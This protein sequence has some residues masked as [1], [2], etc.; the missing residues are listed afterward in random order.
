[1]NLITVGNCGGESGSGIGLLTFCK[2]SFEI[3]MAFHPWSLKV[4]R[5]V[6]QV[7]A[8]ISRGK[9]LISFAL[10][11]KAILGLILILSCSLLG[12]YLRGAT[13]C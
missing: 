2:A 9:D 5:D 6:Y 7:D 13:E 12:E 11:N 1:L 3:D 8:L 4:A 10:A